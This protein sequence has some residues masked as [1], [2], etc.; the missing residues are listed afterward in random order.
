MPSSPTPSTPPTPPKRP[1]TAA[2]SRGSPVDQSAP[3][4]LRHVVHR[5][6]ALIWGGL[7]KQH[8]APVHAARGGENA[9]LLFLAA[10]CRQ[11]PHAATP[12][13]TFA[14]QGLCAPPPELLATSRTALAASGAT[15][16]KHHCMHEIESLCFLLGCCRE[17][18]QDSCARR[19]SHGIELRAHCSE[20]RT[21]QGKHSFSSRTKRTFT[22]GLS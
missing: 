8:G 17:I 16:A 10:V 21:F 1:D 18:V 3:P 11:A 9:V 19:C 12:C 22:A 13:I 20:R 5:E 15:G 14:R 2:D 7:K 6:A 4:W